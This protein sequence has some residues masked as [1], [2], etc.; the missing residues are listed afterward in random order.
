MNDMKKKELLETKDVM[1]ML[2]MSRQ[3][4]YHYHRMGV[5]H[6]VQLVKGG[7]HRWDKEEIEKLLKGK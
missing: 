5:L 1:K 6:S 7:R 2:N 3:L 4:I